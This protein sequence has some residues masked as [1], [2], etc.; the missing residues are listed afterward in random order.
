MLADLSHIPSLSVYPPVF[1]V[2]M[3]LPFH[4]PSPLKSLL[5]CQKRQQ[6]KNNRDV[7]VQLQP[8]ERMTD[9]IRDVL[10]MHSAAFNQDSNGDDRIKGR[11]RRRRILFRSLF[12]TESQIAGAGREEIGRRG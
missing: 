8:H 1:A 2:I 9:R 4:Q 3:H 5:L 11:R 10:E 12:G 7:L 6:S